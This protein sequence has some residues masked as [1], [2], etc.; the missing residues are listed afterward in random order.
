MWDGDCD[1]GA[2]KEDTWTMGV[3]FGGNLDGLGPN[4][5][6]SLVLNYLQW[7][8]EWCGAVVGNCEGRIVG[9]VWVWEK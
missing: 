9:M 1:W 5:T 4:S 6:V 2:Q 8:D 3:K 7:R